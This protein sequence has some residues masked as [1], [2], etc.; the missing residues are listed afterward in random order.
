MANFNAKNEQQ[1]NR[2]LKVQKLSIPFVIVGNAT[3]S[4]VSVSCDEPSLL[5]IKTQGVDQITAALATSET[6]T[7]TTSP[8]DSNGIFNILVRIQEPVNKVVSIRVADRVTGANE[9]AYIGSS[10]G[11]TTGSGGGQS[12]MLTCDATVALNAANTVSGCLEVEYI[13]NEHS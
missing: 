7:Y 2:Q 3:S 8:D 13:V 1:L 4:S 11:I 9:L 5:F 12:I 10:S 6:A